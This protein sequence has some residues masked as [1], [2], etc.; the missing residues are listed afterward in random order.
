MSK[1]KTVFHPAI[2]GVTREVENPEDWK[3]AGWR[4]T[5]PSNADTALTKTETKDTAK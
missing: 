5:E 2:A 4:F 1:T 3:A